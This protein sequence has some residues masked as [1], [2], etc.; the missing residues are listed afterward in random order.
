MPAKTTFGRRDIARRTVPALFD[1]G[2]SAPTPSEDDP[3]IRLY[4]GSDTSLRPRHDRQITLPGA[5]IALILVLALIF[6][7]EVD[8]AIDFT[9]WLSPSRQALIA[10]GGLDGH[11]AIGSGEWW[12]LLTAP[13]LHAGPMH[14][15]GN[16]AVLA[17]IGWYFEPLVGPGWFIGIFA[18]GALGGS[19]G[20]LAQSD[21]DMVSVGASG[22]ISALLAAALVA[23]FRIDDD[24]V[25]RRMQIIAA[26]ILIP[27]VLPVFSLAKANQGHVDYGAHLGG[28]LAGIMVALLLTATWNSRT[29]RPGLK[30]L[31][32]VISCAFTVLTVTSFASAAGRAPVY[33]AETP[34]LIPDSQIPNDAKEAIKHSDEWTARYPNDPRGYFYKGLDLLERNNIPEGAIQLRHALSL[35]SDHQAEFSSGFGHS[36]KIALAIAIR[37]EG[38][39]A[40]AREMAQESCAAPD[41]PQDLLKILKD[42]KICF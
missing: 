10:L 20:S 2:R 23:S 16:C 40:A 38:D 41:A 12:R 3:D 4:D 6:G 9:S 22:A 31:S 24:Q 17:L 29:R 32:I 8:R 19:V 18:I 30:P 25:R 11:L 21:P 34:P 37:A 14:I 28:A 7:M 35:Y 26:R 39:M 13:M 1:P 36:V 42:Q 15:I 27:A 5:T 33:A